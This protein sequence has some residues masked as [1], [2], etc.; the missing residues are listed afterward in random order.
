[1]SQMSKYPGAL[2]AASSCIRLKSNARYKCDS[3]IRYTD[4]ISI[5]FGLSR[6]LCSPIFRNYV[7]RRW[8]EQSLTHVHTDRRGLDKKNTRP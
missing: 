4:S 2:R 7:L 3:G 1:M 5:L 8:N 6:R